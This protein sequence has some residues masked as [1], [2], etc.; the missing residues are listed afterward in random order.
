MQLEKGSDHSLET[1]HLDADPTNPVTGEHK[2]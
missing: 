1:V 2:P